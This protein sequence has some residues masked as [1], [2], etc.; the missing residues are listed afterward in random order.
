[1]EY[2][3]SRASVCFSLPTVSP[4]VRAFV[5]LCA[6]RSASTIAVTPSAGALPSGLG[7]T[8]PFM[9]GQTR[10]KSILHLFGTFPDIVV[11]SRTRLWHGAMTCCVHITS[12]LST[13]GSVV[14]EKGLPGTL[15]DY[16]SPKRDEARLMIA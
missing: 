2:H 4:G 13:S 5:L 10:E 1:M 9:G 16:F 8:F 11:M 15:Y 6:F 14:R 12:F 7:S 3:I